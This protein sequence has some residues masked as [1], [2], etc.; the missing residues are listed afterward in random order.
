MCSPNFF[1]INITLL[2][3]NKLYFKGNKPGKELFMKNLIIYVQGVLLALLIGYVGTCTL[4]VGLCG[5][6]VDI[7]TKHDKE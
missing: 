2:C 1:R 3:S 7:N 6:D 5:L 4:L